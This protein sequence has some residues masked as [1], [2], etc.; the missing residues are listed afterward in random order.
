MLIGL[1]LKDNLTQKVT[2]IVTEAN[3]AAH[4]LQSADIEYNE[5]GK[6]G[7]D[8]WETNNTFQYHLILPI[9]RALVKKV[10]GIIHENKTD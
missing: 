10:K 7:V 3:S 2:Q 1:R 5:S 6:D 4:H 9:K 8:Q